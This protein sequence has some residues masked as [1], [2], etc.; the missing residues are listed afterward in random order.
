MAKTKVHYVCKEC[1]YQTAVAYGKCP[2]CGSWNSFQEVKEV[3]ASPE[4]E[5]EAYWQSLE[6][7]M[8]ARPLSP[9]AQPGASLHGALPTTA[10]ASQ[11]VAITAL[12]ENTLEAPRLSSG[13]TELD[14]V[15]GG[16]LLPGAFVL[17]GGDPGI[18]KSTLML[19][20]A[21]QLATP[22]C[23]VLYVTGE[24]SLR[25]VQGRAK[26][27]EALAEN[28]YLYAETDMRQILEEIKASQPQVVVV[29]SVQAAYWSEVSSPPGSTAQ[30]RAVA[31]L[32]MTVAKS[33]GITVILV[34]HVT[35]EGQL[36]GPKL[37]EHLVDCV[38]YFEGEKY[39]DLRLLRCVKNRFGST[40]ELGVFEMGSHGLREVQNP[41]ELFL[42]AS[43]ANPLP[44]CV[45]VCTLEGS[46]PLLVEIQALVGSSAYASGRR[47]ATGLE[48]TRLH[49]IVAVLERRLGLEFAHQDIYVN[50]VGGL[51]IEEPAADLGVA[52]ALVSSLRN[53]SLA[54]KTVVIGELG[55]TGEVRI[56]RQWRK[57]LLEAEKIGFQR[58]ILPTTEPEE[59]VN[60]V[61]NAALQLFSVNTLLDAVSHAF[62]QEEISGN[63][64]VPDLQ[65][66]L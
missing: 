9:R 54:P 52:L 24:E 26:R 40:Q 41:S 62:Q 60:T 20:A 16:G 61:T 56:V 34:G 47:V 55:L 2:E 43:G 58:V 15:L 51:K 1:S 18:G 19:E 66:T 29:D 35:K 42:G 6:Q 14:R 39:K 48:T 17:L 57:R 13:F 65:N 49:Q 46:R 10:G 59:N 50:V 33:W 28:L 21:A 8:E 12:D 22:E 4:K 30:I 23:K 32:L 25:Q 27:L 31:N 64:N 63:L 37:L 7:V 36:S 44:G 3:K 45:T 5:G 53:I 11:S 38:L